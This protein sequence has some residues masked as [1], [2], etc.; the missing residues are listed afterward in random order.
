MPDLFARTDGFFLANGEQSRDVK[1][2]KHT[3]VGA[4]L[5]NP[6]VPRVIICHDFV[7]APKLLGM[8]TVPTRTGPRNPSRQAGLCASKASRCHRRG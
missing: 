1:Y 6:F 2:W 8:L 4:A 3:P 5:L 7:A